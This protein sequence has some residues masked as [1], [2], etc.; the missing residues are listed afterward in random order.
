MCEKIDLPDNLRL[1]A[2]CNLYC[3][4]GQNV[5]EYIKT[6]PLGTSVADVTSIVMLSREDFIRLAT[7][8]CER[9]DTHDLN[10]RIRFALE[11]GLILAT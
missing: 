7:E 10:V 6:S 5:T 9:R 11:N 3:E 1:D 4:D 8:Y 2:D